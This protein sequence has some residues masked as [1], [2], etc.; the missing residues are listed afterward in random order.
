MAPIYKIE[1][2]AEKAKELRRLGFNLM[3]NFQIAELDRSSWIVIPHE[4]TNGKYSLEMNPARISHNPA[5][6]KA[7]KELGINYKNTSKDSLGREFAGNNNWFQFLRLNQGLGVK[8]P[9]LEE[10]VDYLH[11]LYLGSQNKLKVYDVSGKQVDSELCGKYLMDI[12]E[13]KYPWRAEYIDND[14]KTNG[15]M[16]EVHYNH[17]FDRNGNIADFNSE[18][19]DENTLMEDM[20]IDVIDFIT[21]NHT[22]Q[23]LPNKNVESGRFHSWTPRSDNNSVAWF[24]ADVGGSGL[25]CCGY[26]SDGGA[27]LGVRAAKLRE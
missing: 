5:I 10:E 12:I 13:S 18:V 17:T 21:K 27:S 19:L 15:K 24:V 6:E 16:I 1:T 14:F 22:N 11:L 20:G 9:T 2:S 25:Y 23:G 7:G 3:E 4:F 8:T 26:P